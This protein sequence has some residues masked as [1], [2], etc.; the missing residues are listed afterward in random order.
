MKR[1]GFTLI[2]LLVVIAVIA[3]MIA[4]LLPSLRISRLQAEALLCSSQIKQL[5]LSLTMYEDFNG[6]FPHAFDDTSQ[7]P[8]PGGEPGNPLYDRVGWWWFNHISDHSRKN[9]GKKAPLWCPSR[10][11]KDPQIEHVL[12][13]NYGVNQS[14]CKNSNGRKSRAEFVGTPL[15]KGEI[16]RQG[17]TL[18]IV[19]SGYSM[20]NWWHVTDVPPM[21]LGSSIEDNA[22]LPGLKINKER[23]L[24]LWPGQKWDAIIGRHPKQKV[25]VGFVDGHVERSQ[26]EG[27]F[28]E[29]TETGYNNRYPLWRPI[30][31]NND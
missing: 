27:L 4:I 16:Q 13:S 9:K 25:N 28:V 29:K 30:Q 17:E 18:L 2:E 10:L 20:I 5:V 21:S 31:N 22:Y 26:A 11:I 12:H 1:E 7:E 15:S 19:D 3:L 14:I 6:T 23:S 8:P 24:S